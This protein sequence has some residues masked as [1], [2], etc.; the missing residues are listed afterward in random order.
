LAQFL[1]LGDTSSG[2]R[3]LGESQTDMFLQS[4]TAVAKQICDTINRFLIPELV[5]FNFDVEDYPQLK[6]DPLAGKD[7]EKFA[8][9][10][11]TLIGAAAIN[12]DEDLED[13]LREKYE[14]PSRM[15]EEEVEEV[16]D[17]DKGNDDGDQ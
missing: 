2:S 11:S 15:K 10:I 16:K 6:F 7:L 13:F 17:T 5:D 4:L 14:L 12:P 8:N 3:S 1:E 9:I